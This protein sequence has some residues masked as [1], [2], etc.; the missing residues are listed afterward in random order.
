MSKR[1]SGSWTSLVWLA[2]CCRLLNGA[3]GHKGCI[4]AEVQMGLIADGA[5]VVNSGQKKI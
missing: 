2:G 1:A 3:R 5:V 4:K